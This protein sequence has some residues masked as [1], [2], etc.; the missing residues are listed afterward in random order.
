MMRVLIGL[1][2]SLAATVTVAT[3]C[4]GREPASTEALPQLSVSLIQ[5]RSDEPTH[6][7]QVAVANDSDTEVHIADVQLLTDSFET[8]PPEP[9]DSRLG[10]TPRTDLK[11]PYG[12]ARCRPDRIP[13]VQPARVVTYD[14]PHPDPLLTKLLTAECQA[15]IVAQ[16]AELTFGDTWTPAGDAMRGSLLL[17]RRGGDDP[18]RV[19]TLGDT[20]HF[21]M[22]SLTGTEPVAVLEAGAP[23]IEIPVEIG[24]SRCDAHAFAEAKKA[25]IFPITIAVGVGEPWRITYVPPTSVQETLLDFAQAFCGL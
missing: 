3:G 9:V 17:T 23:S 18:V 24:P 4:S 21:T 10:R 14:L 12:A 16:S 15:H 13:D 20:S 7:L 11:I 2:A 1:A 19:D 25:F 8:L 6:T 22:E 5:L